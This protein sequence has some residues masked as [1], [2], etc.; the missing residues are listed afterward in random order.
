VLPSLAAVNAKVQEYIPV[1]TL[2]PVAFMFPSAVTPPP[3]DSAKADPE[4]VVLSAE[5]E[6]RL[7]YILLVL[8][9]AGISTSLPRT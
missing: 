4:V 9:R 2:L 1:E 3:R 7:T 6:K 5:P 8:P